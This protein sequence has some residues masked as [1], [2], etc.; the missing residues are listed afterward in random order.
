MYMYVTLVH[1]FTNLHAILQVYDDLVP[2]PYSESGGSQVKALTGAENEHFPALKDWILD[3]IS[4][5]TVCH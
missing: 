2:V 4:I 3:T 1:Y 5:N